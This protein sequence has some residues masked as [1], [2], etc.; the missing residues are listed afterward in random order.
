MKADR[1]AQSTRPRGMSLANSLREAKG[2]ACPEWCL[3][4][5]T[6]ASPIFFLRWVNT[7][8]HEFY[9]EH[10]SQGFPYP[11]AI[12]ACPPFLRSYV[13]KNIWWGIG[14]PTAILGPAF[15]RAWRLSLETS[16]RRFLPD[17]D[18]VFCLYNNFVRRIEVSREPLIIGVLAGTTF[19][20][21]RILATWDVFG[22]LYQSRIL[23]FMLFF[24][25]FGLGYMAGT[26]WL[27]L[28]FGV[29]INRISLELETRQKEWVHSRKKVFAKM[30]GTPQR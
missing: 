23:L 20:I 17:N 27:L 9:S 12:R 18:N 30:V 26:I 29:L 15:I 7:D 28:S 25:P 2:G 11:S 10:F 8:E 4:K 13:W 1:R 21:F 16:I 6:L 24:H 5:P 22:T 14:F 19:F 3:V